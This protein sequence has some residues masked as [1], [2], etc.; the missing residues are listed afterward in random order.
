M[1]RAAIVLVCL[2]VSTPA[3]AQT[4]TAPVDSRTFRRSI[5]A[6]TF[7]TTSAEKASASRPL[8]RQAKKMGT[9][10]RIG[11]TALAGLG[12][13][14][15]GAYIGAAIEGDRC[16]CDDPGLQGALIGMPIGTAAAAITTWALTGR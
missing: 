8:V 2:L 15:A 13:F 1:F 16:N 6:V 7:D 14:F 10:E 5:A 3:W 11:W 9:G 12:G 4:S